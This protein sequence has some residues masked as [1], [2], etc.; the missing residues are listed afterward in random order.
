MI[1]RKLAEAGYAVITGGGPG[2]M[3][4]ANRGC[5]EGGGLSIGCN[6]ELPHEQGLNP[7]V[8]LGVEFRYFFVRKV[9]FVKYADA[10]VIMPGGFGTLDE[11]FE[12]LTLIQ[13]EKVRHFPVILVGTDY[14]R[15]LLA[16]VREMPIARGAVSPG[17]L[18]LLMLTDDP[19]EIVRIITEDAAAREVAG[20][21]ED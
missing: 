10:F 13:T 20:A 6:I 2:T 1:G 4:A 5:R 8:D 14:W 19:D 21:S 3:E 12:A 15:G 11:L 7:Y 16:W 9:M 18:D 17:D